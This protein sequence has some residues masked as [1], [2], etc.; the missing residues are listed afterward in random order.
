MR[1]TILKLS[2]EQDKMGTKAFKMK[3][4][5]LQSQYTDVKC[6][7]DAK[8]GSDR[9]RNEIRGL[10]LSA[11]VLLGYEQSKTVSVKAAKNDIV[12]K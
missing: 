12:M 6:W 9:Q 2:E 1:S 8:G 4:R 11:A 5:C 3:A 7:R 10:F